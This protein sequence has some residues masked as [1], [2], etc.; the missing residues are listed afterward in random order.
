MEADDLRELILQVY[1]ARREAKEW[2]EFYL[3]PDIKKKL[4]E[5]SANLNKELNRRHRHMPACRITRLKAILANFESYQPEDD[6]IA[7]L[8]VSVTSALMQYVRIEYPSD[9]FCKSVLRFMISTI[10]LIDKKGLFDKFFPKLTEEINRVFPAGSPAVNYY[11]ADI[12]ESIEN[13]VVKR[14]L[15]PTRS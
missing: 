13:Y 1:E 2:L 5:T 15:G 4:E 9:A 3:N 10:T 12:D 6:M 7:G 11:R 8:Y 14:S